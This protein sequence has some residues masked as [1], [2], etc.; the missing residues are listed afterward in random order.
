MNK[1]PSFFRIDEQV[2][3]AMTGMCVIAL[4]VLAF[5]YANQET[6][7]PIKISFSDSLVAGSII[8]FKAETQGGKTFAWNFGD[9]AEKEEHNNTTT[10]IYKTAGSYTLSILINDHCEETQT[11]LVKEAPVVANTGLLPV[12]EASSDTAYTGEPITVTDVS[13]N[14][15][16]W[17]WFFGETNTVDKSTQEATYIYNTPGYKTIYL[18]I[19][20]RSD[21]T[22]TKDIY[23]ID[24]ELARNNIVKLKPVIP[25][26]APVRPT[27]KDNPQVDKTLTEQIEEKKPAT[28]PEPAKPK[29]PD[30]STDELVTMIKSIAAGDKSADIFNPYLCNNKEIKVAYNNNVMTFQKFCE[31][32]QE[33]K[34]K[35]IKKI[36][37]WRNVNAQTNCIESMVVSIETKKGFWPFN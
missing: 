15:T 27:I 22:R 8:R 1:K 11:F 3:F 31:A 29:A 13:T 18:R 33:L 9:G 19:N 7:S 17:E 32:L 12:I 14:S 28:I 16:S 37:V 6:C 24:K 2:F 36:S 23:V 26:P 34:K 5:Q 25:K 21:L 4:I 35:K 20:G 10:H 30:V